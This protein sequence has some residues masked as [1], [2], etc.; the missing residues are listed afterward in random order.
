MLG[1]VNDSIGGDKYNDELWYEGVEKELIMELGV[2]DY[3]NIEIENIVLVG[4]NSFREIMW[5]ECDGGEED[6]D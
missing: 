1:V 5:S 4:G 2:W 3:V 6:G